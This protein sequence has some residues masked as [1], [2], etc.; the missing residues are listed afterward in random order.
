[1]ARLNRLVLPGLAH[2]VSLNAV[3]GT[4]VFTSARE[5]ELF[6]EALR[7]A[8][9]EHGVTIHAHVLLCTEVQLLLTPR[10]ADDLGRMMQA[11]ARFYVGPFNR[12]QGRSGALWQSRY[13]AGPVGG[14]DELLLCMRYIEQ[15]PRDAGWAAALAE[16][17]WSS[18]A[19]HA[20]VRSQPFLGAVPPASG[21]W[22]LG[23][24]PFER[25]AAYA[26]L[27]ESPLA[28]ND[29]ARVQATTL[30][31]WAL[32]SGE[33]IAS[34]ATEAPRRPVAQARGRPRKSA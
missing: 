13:R 2:H 27:L 1:M 7:R 8:A 11:L 31:G 12:R 20:G 21:Y 4:E 34:L 15:A 10:A 33:F 30:K 3:S 9:S 5:P 18:A 22:L 26:T 24:T 6:I 29:L 23:N 14:P 16:Y 19:H 32:G 17:P 28:A 25:E